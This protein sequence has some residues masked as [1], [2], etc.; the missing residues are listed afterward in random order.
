MPP[1]P[2]LLRSGGDSPLFPRGLTL[3]F[4]SNPTLCAF[5][6]VQEVNKNVARTHTP[7]LLQKRYLNRPAMLATR[8]QL[9]TIMAIFCQLTSPVSPTHFSSGFC[10]RIESFHVDCLLESVTSR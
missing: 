7:I 9:A 4:A 3:N 8:H 1:H 6:L 2:H 5:R 10:E